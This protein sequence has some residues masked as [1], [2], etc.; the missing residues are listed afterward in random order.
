M[1]ADRYRS[2]YEAF[3][4][5]VPAEF[6]LA[7]WTCRRWAA[8]RSRI[9]VHW[10]DESG[11]TRTV[12]YRELMEDASRLANALAHL[13]VGHG[14][15]VAII[16]PQRPE[17][18]VAYLAIY[19]MG[20]VAVPMSFLFGADALEYRLADSDSK[21]AFVD[22]VTLERLWPVRGRLPALAHVVGVAGAME[23]GVLAWE[24]LLGKADGT[25]T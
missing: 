21:V 17:T 13:G 7:H 1:S 2:L 19:Q 15:R 14:D 8:D 22:P 18:V 4:W 25:F 16:L 12:T 11:E 6:N 5:Q 3:R 20:A 23:S 9:A 10:E 24:A